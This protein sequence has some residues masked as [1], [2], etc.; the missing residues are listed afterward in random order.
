MHCFVVW[1]RMGPNQQ[2][3]ETRKKGLMFTR[4]NP[5]SACGFALISALC[6]EQYSIMLGISNAI[7]L[8]NSRYGLLCV[9]LISAEIFIASFNSSS[10]FRYS[11][12]YM[13]I[14]TIIIV[15]KLNVNGVLAWWYSSSAVIRSQLR[16]LMLMHK[17]WVLKRKWLNFISFGPEQFT[18]LWFLHRICLWT[19]CP[20]IHRKGRW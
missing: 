16:V 4:Q 20:V 9:V 13:S 7:F 10:K 12:Y 5:C 8:W 17:K 19:W 11:T 18:L 3:L 1:S 15:T 6:A 14:R 2:I